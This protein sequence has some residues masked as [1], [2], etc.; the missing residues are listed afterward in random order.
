[1][2][3][4]TILWV[5]VLATFC[6]ASAGWAKSKQ[7][8]CCN[9]T[10]QQA[11][12]CSHQHQA[13]APGQSVDATGTSLY[14]TTPE[15]VSFNWVHGHGAVWVSQDDSRY[16]TPL[17]PGSGTLTLTGRPNGFG[18]Y[19]TAEYVVHTDSPDTVVVMHAWPAAAAK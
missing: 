16:T 18:G 3:R 17:Y 19:Q 10:Q 2:R 12:H 14:V 8:Q 9:C 4:L 5:L 6:V 1:M 15:A 11:C 13:C 7:K